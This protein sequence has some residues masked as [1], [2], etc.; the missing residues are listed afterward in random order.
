[1][2]RKKSQPKEKKN[3]PDQTLS[4]LQEVIN[5]LLDC[6]NNNKDCSKCPYMKQN[7]LIFMRDSIAV[8]LKFILDQLK[9]NIIAQESIDL[10]S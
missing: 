3:S 8:A 6:E 1:M 4:D 10:Y 5:A 9:S 7:C 2:P